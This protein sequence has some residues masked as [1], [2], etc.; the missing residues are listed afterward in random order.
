M[1]PHI[2]NNDGRKEVLANIEVY[3]TVLST[4]LPYI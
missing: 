3:G 4:Y 2:I 1:T